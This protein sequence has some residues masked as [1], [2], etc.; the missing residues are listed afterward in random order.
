[1]SGKAKFLLVL[2]LIYVVI[3]FYWQIGQI[4]LLSP[5]TDIHDRIF[6]AFCG[7]LLIA[8]TFVWG[9]LLLR[10]I[11]LA[12][13]WSFVLAIQPWYI[14]ESRIFSLT[15]QVTLLFV[16]A[17]IFCEIKI[18]NKIAKY[19][20]ITAPLSLTLLRPEFFRSINSINSLFNNNFINNIFYP[21]SFRFLFFQNDSFWWG[22]VREIGILLPFFI[23]FFIIGLFGIPEL[24]KLHRYLLVWFIFFLLLN[25]LNPIFPEGRYF[26]P[27]MPILTLIIV[28]GIK[29][30][31]PHLNRVKV[32]ILLVIL[33]FL[34]IY[35]YIDFLHTYTVHYRLRVN[36]DISKI[37]EKF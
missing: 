31:L 4:P 12:L 32:K 14:Q 24:T 21:L 35:N 20:L 22:G 29:Q 15:L 13:L 23:P 28:A 1:M 16:L 33:L 30:L 2:I 6:S 9:K 37:N 34:F 27:V 36:T 10:S 8:A 3:L 26:F 19:L 11:K 5:S 7:V 25:A 17:S 18:Q